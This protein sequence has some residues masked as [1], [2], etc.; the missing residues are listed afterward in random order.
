MT[1]L[2]DVWQILIDIFTDYEIECGTCHNERWNLQQWLW[3]IISAVIPP[4][5]VIEMPKWPD[6]ELDFSDINL[7][8]NLKY[9]V[10]DLSFY[11]ITLPDAPLP[12]VNGFDLPPM[13]QLPPL[14]DLNIDFEIPVIQ[15]P[16]LPNLPP[17]PKIPELSQSIQVVLKIFQLVTLIQCLYRKIPLSPEWFV[18]TKVAHKTERQ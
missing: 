13:P 8:L 6:I 16:K 9:P 17:P 3:I 12:S 7:S 2:W 10:F 4:I 18:G 11:P 14:P 5:P 1:K 15:L